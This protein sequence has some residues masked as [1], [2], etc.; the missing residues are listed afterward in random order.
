MEEAQAYD[1]W[2]S[3]SRLMKTALI[4]RTMKSSRICVRAPNSDERRVM[5]VDWRPRA[6]RKLDHI[7]EHI[8]EQSLTAAD[9]VL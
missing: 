9:F 1:E 2:K 7:Q 3:A 4:F 6:E 8:S 5:V